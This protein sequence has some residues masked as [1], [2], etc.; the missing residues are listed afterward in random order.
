MSANNLIR[1][2]RVFVIKPN[3]ERVDVPHGFTNPAAVTDGDRELLPGKGRSVV[4]NATIS[5]DLRR[6]C[7]GELKDE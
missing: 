1:A 2:A 6:P 4:C 7:C 3:G 5:E